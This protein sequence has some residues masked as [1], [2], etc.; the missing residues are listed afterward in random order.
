MFEKKIKEVIND[1]RSRYRHDH[2]E[3]ALII[4]ELNE[5]VMEVRE[6]ALQE[7]M[8]TA[9]T[10]D[11]KESIRKGIHDLMGEEMY[12]CGRDSSAWKYD[13]MRLDDFSLLRDDGDVI[14][15]FVTTFENFTTG[16]IKDA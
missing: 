4:A 2:E 1:V 7:G 10:E 14:E 16:R 13:S 12:Y 9:F 6:E 15:D 5:Y 3:W 8:E 11:E